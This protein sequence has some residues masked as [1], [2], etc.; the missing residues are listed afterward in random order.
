MKKIFIKL[1]ITISTVLVVY[2]FISLWISFSV[3]GLI[4]QVYNS[5][6]N[7]SKKVSGMISKND[8]EQM[9]YRDGYP[10]YTGKI[11]EKNIRTF[12][13]SIHIFYR[14]KVYYTY[15]YASMPPDPEIIWDICC[16]EEKDSD[17]KFVFNERHFTRQ[18]LERM[19]N[20]DFTNVTLVTQYD[21]EFIKL[22]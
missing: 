10:P 20:N 17:G 4:N 11:T 3:N 12:P 9:D 5:H 15:T 2:I 1:L 16:W 14:S 13:I 18:N 19:E 21:H 6:G 7:Y 8:F 22:L